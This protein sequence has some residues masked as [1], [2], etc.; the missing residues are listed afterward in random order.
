[1][2]ERKIGE[3]YVLAAML[4]QVINHLKSHVMYDS[5]SSMIYNNYWN[6]NSSGMINKVTEEFVVDTLLSG[7]S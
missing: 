7:W 4:Y 3:G 1:M 2:G 6:N 5:S